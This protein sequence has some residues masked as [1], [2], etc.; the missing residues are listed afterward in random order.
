MEHLAEVRDGSENKIS[1]G[2]WTVRVIGAEIEKLEITP[3]YEHLYS[4]NAPH[5]VTEN[6]DILRALE[7]V[8]SR[9]LERGVEESGVFQYAISSR[10]YCKLLEFPPVLGVKRGMRCA[11]GARELR[12]KKGPFFSTKT[13][14]MATFVSP[15]STGKTVWQMQRC[16]TCARRRLCPL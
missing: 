9:T 4:Q 2:Y 5:F 14:Q 7:C 8:R 12:R 15:A 13:T 6:E 1:R 10:N 3:L 16:F 11:F